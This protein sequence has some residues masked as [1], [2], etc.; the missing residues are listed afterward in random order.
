MY[1]RTAFLSQ[2]HAEAIKDES[3][4]PQRA[5]ISITGPIS[6][7]NHHSR[8]PRLKNYWGDVLRLVF[9]DVDPKKVSREKARRSILFSEA[10]AVEVLKFLRKNENLRDELIVHCEAGVSRSAGLS[11]FVA[12][13]FLPNFER[14][15][16]NLTTCEDFPA[17]PSSFACRW[18][19]YKPEDRGGT[20]HCKVGV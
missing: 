14:R 18:C 9:H 16:I 13:R 10:Q 8:E 5:I 12:L 15:F 20:G 11:K 3:T 4:A 19:P 2:L 1:K 7:T 6:K 17:S